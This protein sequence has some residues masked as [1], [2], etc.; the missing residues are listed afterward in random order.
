VESTTKL[1][2]VANKT[3]FSMT[4]KPAGDDDATLFNFLR[5]VALQRARCD[6]SKHYYDHYQN[7][8]L[9]HNYNHNGCSNNFMRCDDQRAMVLQSQGCTL[10]QTVWCQR[11]A[12][13][14]ARVSVRGFREDLVNIGVPGGLHQLQY[15]ANRQRERSFSRWLLP[16]TN[17]SRDRPIPLL[18]CSRR[19]R[20][21]LVRWFTL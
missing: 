16:A 11:C 1:F 6:G 5:A 7:H 14:L 3:F 4:Q 8:N 12:E 19:V 2:H 21:A 20:H 10:R 13:R 17:T 18:S 15:V 9:K